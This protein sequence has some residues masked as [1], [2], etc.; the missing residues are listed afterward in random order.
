RD[1]VVERAVVADLG[2]FTDHDAHAMIYEEPAPDS[3]PRMNLDSSE[4]A[5]QVR[6]EPRKPFQPPGPQ[7][8]RRAVHDKRVKA[9]VA[10]KHLPARA[11]GRIPFKNNGY[12]F[13]EVVKHALEIKAVG[14]RSLRCPSKSVN[15]FE[16]A[17]SCRPLAIGS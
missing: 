3:C 17:V 13:P 14:G 4:P 5:R 10:R 7:P 11:G 1:A 12:I 2:R 6:N 16:D 9:R 15:Y 8:V